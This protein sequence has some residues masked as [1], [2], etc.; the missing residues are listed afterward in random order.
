MKVRLSIAYL[1]LLTAAL[2]AFSRNLSATGSLA[3]PQSGTVASPQPA[4]DPPPTTEDGI[5]QRKQKVKGIRVEPPKVY[6]DTLLQQMLQAAEAR[7]AAI[8]ILDQTGIASHLGAV[9]GAT[10]QVSSFGL[11]VQGP[12]LPGVATTDTGATEKTEVTKDSSGKKRVITSA[13]PTSSVVTTLAQANPP[14]VSAP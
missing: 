14:A 3:P 7:L 11:N 1:L 2:A 13:L 5:T 10:Q 8:Q 4:P 12:S 9:T 6:D